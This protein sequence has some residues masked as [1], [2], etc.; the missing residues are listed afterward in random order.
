M[1]VL[2]RFIP[3]S[4]LR[5]ELSSTAQKLYFDHF[6][7]AILKAYYSKIFQNKDI[8]APSYFDE[9]KFYITK[10]K[11]ITLSGK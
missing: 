4:K 9:N 1:Q 7:V 11:I 5:V 10:N 2:H 8:L 6:S 3:S